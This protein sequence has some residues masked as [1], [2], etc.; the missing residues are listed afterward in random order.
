[1][2]MLFHKHWWSR[3]EWWHLL[4]VLPVA[5]PGH[6]KWLKLFYQN[7]SEMVTSQ[8]HQ[9]QRTIQH[10]I[11]VCSYVYIYTN[12]S[13]LIHMY[14]YI[15]HLYW[16]DILLTSCMVMPSLLP[17]SVCWPYVL[18]LRLERWCLFHPLLHQRQ[19]W[20]PLTILLKGTACG[21]VGNPWS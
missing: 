14:I 18:L 11:V 9:Q 7:W 4:A 16:N 3:Y 17:L 6:W 12:E 19:C 15:Y 21:I 1:M 20:L 13:V 8:Q 5:C 2:L 10:I